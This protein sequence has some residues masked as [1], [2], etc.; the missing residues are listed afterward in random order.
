MFT[1]LEW[2]FTV[3]VI[4]LL[5]TFEDELQAMDFAQAKIHSLVTAMEFSEDGQPSS[6]IEPEAMKFREVESRFLQQFSMPEEEKLV[7]C[8]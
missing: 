6:P 4:V 8:K 7:N 3:M 5:G 2:N 1:V